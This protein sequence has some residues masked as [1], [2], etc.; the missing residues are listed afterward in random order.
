ME[1]F[2]D[3]SLE[4]LSFSKQLAKFSTGESIETSWT[5]T[6]LDMFRH[7]VESLLKTNLKLEHSVKWTPA[8]DN[9]TGKEYLRLIVYTIDWGQLTLEIPLGIIFHKNVPL[10]L[11]KT[12]CNTVL[13]QLKIK[14]KM[15]IK[16]IKENDKK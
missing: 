11:P 13:E 4:K 14:Q 8:K 15:L 3:G 6:K 2:E 12:I 16:R 10:D 9:I 1:K 7:I 5:P